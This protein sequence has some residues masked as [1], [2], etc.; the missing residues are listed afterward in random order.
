MTNAIEIS[1][2]H[3][4]ARALLPNT[5]AKK[6][7]WKER[8]DLEAEAKEVAY[9]RALNRLGKPFEKASIEIFVTS[10]DRRRRSLRGFP[11]ACEPW[12]RG[13]ILAGVIKGDDYFQIPK[14][15]ITFQGVSKEK[16]TIL[17]TEM[18]EDNEPVR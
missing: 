10:G 9:D 15:S 12:I 18:E 11:E 16:V 5:A 6:L 4:P 1:F 14:R 13:L 8:D 2:D 17:I 3:W 7:H